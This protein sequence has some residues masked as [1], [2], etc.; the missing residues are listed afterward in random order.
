MRILALLLI[1]FPAPALA[2]AWIPGL[3]LDCRPEINAFVVYPAAH[4]AAKRH[5]LPEE[6]WVRNNGPL[7]EA[8]SCT[9]GGVRISLRREG[10]GSEPL[11]RACAGVPWTAWGI[12]EGDRLAATFHIGCVD[13]ILV[14]RDNG[15]VLCPEQEECRFASWEEL[16]RDPFYVMSLGWWKN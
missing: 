15:L 2:G 12:Y 10:I 6:G 13:S 16:A 3:G 9:L 14:A 5:P 11:G 4:D 1:L 8:A 7:G